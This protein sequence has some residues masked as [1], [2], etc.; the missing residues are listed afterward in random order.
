MLEKNQIAGVIRTGC[1]QVSLNGCIRDFI[2]EANK[3]PSGSRSPP[4]VLELEHLRGAMVLISERVISPPHGGKL[5]SRIMAV[6][7]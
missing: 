4:N 5:A 1:I 2:L 3:R 6:I 7:E